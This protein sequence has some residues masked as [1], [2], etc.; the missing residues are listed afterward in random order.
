MTDDT[1]LAINLA[2]AIFYAVGAVFLIYRTFYTRTTRNGWLLGF[3][4]VTLILH[5][6]GG[7]KIL[8]HPQG[9]DLGIFKVGSLIFWVINTLILASG[10][11]KPL[12]TL[13][14]FL[15]PLSS[16]FILM[17]MFSSDTVTAIPLDTSLSIHI[18]LSIFAYSFLII[19]TLQALVLS[20]QDYQLKH[21]H[22][23]I[24]IRLLPPLQTMEALFFELLWVG[25]ILLTLAIVTGFLF[26]EDLFAQ[27]LVH[28]TLLSIFAWVIYSTLL[29][30]H[31]RLGW[32]G[33]TA[34]RW[35]VG[36]FIILLL[37][38]FGSKFVLE[39]LLQ[40]P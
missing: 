8:H 5:A 39:I 13:F 9:L 23:A 7:I 28:K 25:Q 15:F 18:M 31:Y 16:I 33:K 27:H 6:V 30:G 29:L 38:Y 20:Y 2:A 11:R 19:A 36:G 40:V 32:R 1:V 14:V 34:V 26:L 24:I 10:L 37:A 17:A 35:A 22:P 4:A 3:T 12:H 21:K